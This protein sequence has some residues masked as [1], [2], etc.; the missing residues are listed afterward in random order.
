MSSR[1]ETEIHRDL[2]AG[3]DPTVDGRNAAVLA[4]AAA[5]N[6]L[7]PDRFDPWDVIDLRDQPTQPATPSHHLRVADAAPNR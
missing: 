5:F 2:L 4:R 1:S 6:A 3:I 7:P